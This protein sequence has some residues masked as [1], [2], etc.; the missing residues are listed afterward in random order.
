MSINLTCTTI[1]VVVLTLDRCLSCSANKF[2]KGESVVCRTYVELHQADKEL[3]IQ[4]KKATLV[5]A[6][7]RCW[8]DYRLKWWSESANSEDG[9]RELFWL[10]LKCQRYIE[11]QCRACIP[12]H[13]DSIS[14][15]QVGRML[16]TYRSRAPMV[17]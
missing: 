3:R 8:T 6:D 16:T 13:K 5:E 4:G 12:L 15:T 2:T 7:S 10:S 9:T 11:R 1:C 14:G 17:Y